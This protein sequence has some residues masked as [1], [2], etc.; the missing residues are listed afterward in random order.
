MKIS[1]QFKLGKSQAELDFIDI[2]VEK[3]IPLFIDSHLIGTSDHPFSH[4]CHKTIT[5]FFNFFLELVRRGEV[6]QA[7]A[8]FSHLHEPNETCLGSSKGK[9]NGRGVANKQ[10]SE[11]FNSI[12]QSKAIETGVLEHLEDFR[13]FV[14]GIGPDKVS[15]MTTNIIRFNLIE[16]TQNQCALHGIPLQAEVASGPFWNTL[17]RQWEWGHHDMLVIKGRPILLVPKCLVSLGRVYSFDRYY[18]RYLL[19]F[20]KHDHYLTN[21]PFVRHKTLANGEKRSWVTKDDMRKHVTPPD[22]DF[23]AGYTQQHKDLFDNFR[24]EAGK[25]AKPLESQEIDGR[26]IISDIALHLIEKLKNTPPGNDH[27]S[28]YHRLIVGILELVFYPSLTCPRKEQ[29]INQGRK[30]IDIVFDNSAASGELH[31]LHSVRKISSSYVMVECKNY[32]KDVANPELDQLAGRFSFRHG[33]FGL[34]VCRSVAD[35]PTLIARCHDLYTAKHE[36]ILPVLDEDIL[37]MLKKKADSPTERPEEE[38]LRD[39]IREVIL[40][41]AKKSKPI[42]K[43]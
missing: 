7:R 6:D 21:G 14:H 11:I 15:D 16:Y 4:E 23:V 26:V 27:A 20:V 2:D 18:N 37:L 19:N 34:L 1:K 24:K 22:K 8:L 33:E 29:E 40:G 30:R 32:S 36:L 10:A 38:F 17:N 41:A 28:D 13:I 35:Y 31:R 12:M 39:R 5:S 43:H 42:K 9:P 3:D 25:N